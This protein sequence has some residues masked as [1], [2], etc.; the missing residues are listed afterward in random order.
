[1]AGVP[2]SFTISSNTAAGVRTKP[3]GDVF[4]VTAERLVT[5]ASASSVT[6]IAGSLSSLG[7]TIGP[8]G[9]E[10][11]F[12]HNVRCNPRRPKVSIY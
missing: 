2:A 11:H 4:Y 9:T 5:G 12:T 10:G 8:T 1:M 6:S 3:S 7:N